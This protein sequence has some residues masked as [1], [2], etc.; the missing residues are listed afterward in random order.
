M[1]N[2]SNRTT[3]VLIIIMLVVGI[4]SLGSAVYLATSA[5]NTTAEPA[6]TSTSDTLIE[7]TAV[8]PTISAPVNQIA[9][10]I[11]AHVQTYATSQTTLGDFLAEAEIPLGLHDEVL[12]NGRSVPR[13]DLYDTPLPEQVSIQQIVPTATPQPTATITAV[14]YTILVDD[15]DPNRPEWAYQSRSHRGRSGYPAE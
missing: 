15:H 4:S 10:Q 11:G 8:P 3:A 6:P 2:L 7:A 9:V 13:V 5:D 1:K 14:S 12:V